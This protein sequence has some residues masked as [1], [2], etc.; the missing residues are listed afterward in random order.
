M[1]KF[2]SLALVALLSLLTLSTEVSAKKKS[3]VDPK[4]SYRYDVEY[5]KSVGTGVSQV[6]ICCFTNSKL[7]NDELC[8]RNAVHAI[9][10]KGYSGAG[11]NHPALVRDADAEATHQVFFNEFFGEGGE[12]GRFVTGV[13]DYQN[14]QFRNEFKYSAVVTVNVAA[15]RKYLEQKGVVRSLASGF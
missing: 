10:F 14:V 6:T 1:K 2:V 9:I 11:S 7:T 12:Y 13:T 8:R 3:G 4:Q 15:L 5:V